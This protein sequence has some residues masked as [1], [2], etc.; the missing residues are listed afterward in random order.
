MTAQRTAHFVGIGGVGMSWLARLL[1]AQ[2][3]RVTGSDAAEGPLVPKLRAEGALVAIGHRAENVP[4]DAE[5]VVYTAAVRADN[6]ELTAARA[7]GIRTVKRAEYLGELAQGRRTVAIAG[8]HGKTTTTAMAGIA[9]AAAGLNPTVM[10]GGEVPEFG[11]TLRVGSGDPLVVEADEFDGS[12]LHLCP[13]V[14]VVTNV[15]PEHLD[16]Y[17]SFQRVVEAF[18][19]FLASVPAGGHAVV[20]LDDPVLAGLQ[21]TRALG[22][23]SKLNPEYGL[24]GGTLSATI[25]RTSSLITYGFHPAAHWRP[26]DVRLNPH[27]GFSFTALH[28]GRPACT[29]SLAVPGRH[30]VANALGALAA[31]AALGAEPAAAAPALSAFRGVDRRFQVLGEAAGV[32]VVDDYGHHPT[33]VRAT[34]AAARVRYGGRRIWCV[35]QPHTYSRTKLLLAGFRDAFGDADVVTVTDVYAAREDPADWD[36]SGADL[37]AGLNHKDVRFAPTLEA[38]ASAV[39]AGV[40]AGDVVL[41]MGAGDIYKAGH[42]VLAGLRSRDGA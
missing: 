14:A 38:A 27:G 40:R 18:G 24:A 11:S 16:F 37:A 1:L 13:T 20:C 31:A 7:R 9:L 4:A 35:F 21:S 42:A 32:T 10:V 33:E 29:L 19:A 6:P 26:E 30:N 5:L 41:V 8:T 25:L 39:L 3:W 34:L 17:G 12:F 22:P 36:V 15:E 23:S 2:G 28:H